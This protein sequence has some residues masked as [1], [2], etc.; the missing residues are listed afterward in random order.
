[1]SE[2]ESFDPSQRRE[3][4]PSPETLEHKKRIAQLF[5]IGLNSDDVYAWHGTTIEAIQH[6]AETGKLPASGSY[7]DK[8]FYVPEGIGS[9]EGDQQQAETY[10]GINAV[11]YYLLNKLTFKPRNM[12]NFMHMF[13]ND[14]LFDEFIQEATENGMTEKDIR[15]IIREAEARRKGVLLT[16]SKRLKEDFEEI[17]EGFGDEHCVITQGGFSIDYI[18][19][20]EPLGQ[21]EWEELEKLQQKK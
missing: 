5:E 14:E 6:L 13:V 15:R 19:G 16:L 21:Y 8:F 20:I 7:G 9:Y 4:E 10:A 12:E 18:T 17:S 3:K 11:K 2:R 1:M